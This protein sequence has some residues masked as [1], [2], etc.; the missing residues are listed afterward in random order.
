MTEN[1]YIKPIYL[2]LNPEDE[3]LECT[4]C[5]ATFGEYCDGIQHWCFCP[6]CGKP[7][8]WVDDVGTLIDGQEYIA[9]IMRENV[10]QLDELELTEFRLGGGY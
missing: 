7:L 3:S 10:R 5:G 9:Q 6:N 1:K 4:N 2:W 8:A